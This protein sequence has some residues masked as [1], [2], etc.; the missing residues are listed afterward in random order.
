M[1]LNFPAD[2]SNPYIDPASGLKYI[3]NNTVGA[4][5]TAIQPP[6]IISDDLPRITIPGFLWWDSEEGTLFIYYDDGSSQQWVEA[7]PAP[8]LRRTT[9]NITPPAEPIPGDLWWDPVTGRLYIYYEDSDSSQWVDAAPNGGG[10]SAGGGGT[11]GG[12]NVAVSDTAPASPVQGDLWFDTVSGNL[13]IYYDD[14]DSTQWVIVTTLQDVGG[15]GASNIIG[16]DPI[17]VDDSTPGTVSISASVATTTDTGVARFATTAEVNAGTEPQAA[18]TPAALRQS[19][20][21]A[22]NLPLASTTQVG[23]LET[24]TDAEAIVGTSTSVAVTPSNLAAALPAYGVGAPA[25]MVIAY[26]GQTPPAG[27]LECDGSAVSRNTYADLFQVVGTSFGIG[28]GIT[29]FNLPDLRGEFIRGWDNGKGTDAGRNL[30]SFQAD[31]I[32]AHNHVGVSG[33]P[34]G[35]LSGGGNRG[36]NTG[37]YTTNSTGGDETR[38]R[39][40]ALMYCIKF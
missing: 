10:N 12:A 11:V 16:T 4:W 27:Y 40:I 28:N 7:V 23:V 9:I 8:D 30:G 38:P 21:G 14:G 2:T 37:T 17:V 33:P 3:Y 29:T 32:R 39:N 24:A 15:G 13:F 1:A 35:G 18:V 36:T 34:T 20:A 19:L 6:A 31:E 22:N 26:G 5:E 25:G